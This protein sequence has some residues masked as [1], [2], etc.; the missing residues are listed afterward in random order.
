MR[1]N[2]PSSSRGRSLG[3]HLASKILLFVAL[4]SCLASPIALSSEAT[5]DWVIVAHT[6]MEPREITEA[7]VRA[8]YNLRAIHW[9]DGERVIVTTLP[10]TSSEF[11]AFASALGSSP[12][13]LHREWKYRIF[14]G[15]ATGPREMSS[16]DEM[17]SF[18]ATTPGAIGF[19]P[20]SRTDGIPNAVIV[21]P[22]SFGGEE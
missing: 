17:I 3:A 18:I 4:A 20:R 16:F 6:P 5:S 19:I 8:Y 15:A 9:P 7:R 12:E 21:L 10:R 22:V 13:R 11:Y 14:T 2:W 1:Y